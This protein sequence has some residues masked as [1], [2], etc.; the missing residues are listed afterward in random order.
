MHPVLTYFLEAVTILAIVAVLGRLA[1]LIIRKVP[2]LEESRQFNRAE[3]KK[4]LSKDKYPPVVKQNQMMG[5]LMFTPLLFFVTPFFASFDAVPWYRYFTDVLVIYLVYDFLYYLTH[6]FLFHGDWF[7]G[8][9]K[10]VHGLHHQ[11]RNPSHIDAQYVHPVETFLGL[12]LLWIAVIG[13]GL[14]MPDFNVFSMALAYFFY[15]HINIL[16]HCDVQ[17]AKKPWNIATWISKRHHNH[18]IDM[19]HGNYST[20]ILAI[21]WAFGT[22][23]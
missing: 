11:A 23:E 21:D 1:R 3:D 6:R 10:R 13:T 12:L 17:I 22:Y 8:Y 9:F 7:G 18:H 15:S 19:S 5:L 16:N 4:R 14:V 2:E 20:L